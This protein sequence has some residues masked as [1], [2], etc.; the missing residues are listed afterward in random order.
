MLRAGTMSYDTTRAPLDGS[1][2]FDG[3]PSTA[4]IASDIFRRMV[5]ELLDT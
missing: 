4:G 1:V 5:S 2:T 3:V